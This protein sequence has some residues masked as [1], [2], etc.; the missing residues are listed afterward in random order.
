[1]SRT[2]PGIFDHV[3]HVIGYDAQIDAWTM[4][5]AYLYIGIWRRAMGARIRRRSRVMLLCMERKWIKGMWGHNKVEGGMF[6]TSCIWKPLGLNN[7]RGY[8][9][10]C[11]ILW[12][13]HLNWWTG[14]DGWV[15]LEVKWMCHCKVWLKVKIFQPIK[16]VPAATPLEVH[17]PT[18]KSYSTHVEGSKFKGNWSI[19]MDDI[20]Q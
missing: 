18:R 13:G 15:D 17:F 6:C 20:Q 16:A 2:W 11:I 1:M 19:E 3:M 4:W 8:C 14:K 5:T 7:V 9:K 10:D 12:Q